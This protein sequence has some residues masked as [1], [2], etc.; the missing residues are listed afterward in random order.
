ML[1]EILFVLLVVIG[2]AVIVPKVNKLI[3]N[4]RKKKERE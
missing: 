2:A 1:D 3:D 4:Q